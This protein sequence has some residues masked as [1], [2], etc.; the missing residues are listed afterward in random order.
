MTKKW[1]RNILSAAVVLGFS[2]AVQ[3]AHAGAF[4]W[5]SAPTWTYSAAAASSPAG[6][7][8]FWGLSIGVGTYSW[9]YAFSNSPFGSA[10]SF[11]EAATGFGGMGGTQ[12]AG[13]ADPFA[14]DSIDIT[15]L[16]PANPGG[17]PTTDP[18]TDPF[19]ASYSVSST[20]IT[21][22]GS[23]SELNGLDEVQAFLYT[24]GTG[25]GTIEGDLGVSSMSGTSQTGDDSTIGALTNSFG[26]VPLDAPIM[27]PSSLSGITF[28]ENDSSVNTADVIL[29][30]EGDA[31]S[32]PEPATAWG[33]AAGLLGLALL[34]RRL[35]RAT[36]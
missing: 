28:T 26:L 12:V 9:A 14:G 10:F 29:V 4:A 24:G 36:A 11:A 32:T 34:T 17:F 18:S 19:S 2:G 27:D 30:G 20:G 6:T 23:G 8:Y 25:A 21:F 7:A 1:R 22:T 5:I 3:P 16:N 13:I 15:L 35:R 33:L 31:S